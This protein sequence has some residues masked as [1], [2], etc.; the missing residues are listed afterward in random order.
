[1]VTMVRTANVHDGKLDAALAWAVKATKYGRDK[2]SANIQLRRNIGG[3]VHQV[4]WVSTH[5]SLADFEKASKRAEAD[6]GYKALLAE[7]RQQG[8]F[9]ASSIV[10]SLYEDIA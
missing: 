6:E 10:D 3:A 2:L 9:S 5:E 7:A 8:L 1:M 4:H